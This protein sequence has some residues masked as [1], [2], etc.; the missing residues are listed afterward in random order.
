VSASPSLG[1]RLR[2]TDEALFA[3]LG[4]GLR[5]NCIPCP[6]HQR[7]KP[8]HAII[9][10]ARRTTRLALLKAAPASLTCSNLGSC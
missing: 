3:A 1:Y 7:D 4:I 9:K 6:R 8:I 2:S 5:Q 10:A